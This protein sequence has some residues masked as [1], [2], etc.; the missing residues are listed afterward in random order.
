[1]SSRNDH[2]SRRNF[3]RIAG[4]TAAGAGVAACAPQT[5]TVVVTQQVEK[6][7]EVTKEVEVEK[8]VEV[9]STAPP[10]LVTKQGRELPADAAPLDRQ[11]LFDSG[12]EPKHLDCARS[13]YDGNMALN[14]GVEPMLRRD[15]NQKLVPAIAESWTPGPENAYWDFKLREGAQWSDGTPLTPDDWV[16]TFKHISD[17]KLANPWVWFYYDVK[18]VK[19]HFEGTGGPEG[20]GV[21][22]IDD[23]TVRIHGEGPIPHLPQLMAYQN[24]VPVPKHV[25][26]SNP[27]HWADS[28]ETYVA[29]GPFIPTKWD[30]NKQIVWDI[31]PNYNGPHK[32]AFRR[33][34]Q[35]LTTPGFNNWLNGE[36]DLVSGMDVPTLSFVRADPKLNALLHFF[37][38]FQS[39]YLA[40]DTMNPPLNN[41]K[42]RQALA[43][44]I[45]RETMCYQVMAGTYVPGYSMLPPGFPGYNAEL[46]TAQV[47]DV[48]MAKE[49]LTAAGYPEGKDSSGNQLTLEMFA[50]ARDARMEFVKEQWETNLG[51]KVN[52]NL[53]ENSVWGEKRGKHEMMIYKGPYEYD[54]LDPA[55]L[56]TA[57]WKSTSDAG[58]PRHAWKNDKFDQLVTDAPKEVDEAKR[59][60]MYQEAEK[61][62][63]DEDCAAAFISHQVIFQ[64]WWPYFTGIPADDSGNVVYRYLD[65]SRFQAYMRNDENEYR[66]QSFE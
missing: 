49:L 44:A 42:L 6:Q 47:Y 45:D 38:N 36:I 15:Q 10:A 37:N 33:V 14:T 27:E 65:I 32:P 61:I 4:M 19:A 28:P 43:H 52:L 40:F 31:N 55:N 18:G 7:V 5:V 13:V 12:G 9:T 17:P 54:Y 21:E 30:H 8:V 2:F 41:V 3:L 23:R 63:V 50:N 48:A 35:N 57:L 62:L 46:K 26:E 51:I 59:I 39:E 16:Y 11:V 53:I 29:C 64:I 66:K 22:K 58:S 56:L 24:A 20:I 60:A 34:I 25:A 1:M